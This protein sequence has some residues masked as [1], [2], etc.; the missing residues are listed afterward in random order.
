MRNLKTGRV[1]GLGLALAALVCVFAGFASNA[2][3][4]VVYDQR[5]PLTLSMFVPCAN[6]GAGEVVDVTGTWHAFFTLVQQGGV[7]T[8]TGH[9][10]FEGLVGMGET[11]GVT[12]HGTWTQQGYD[13]TVV[14]GGVVTLT[15]SN[16]IVFA[17]E[18]GAGTF[19]WIQIAHVTIDPA[20]DLRVNFDNNFIGCS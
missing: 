18:G 5:F 2:R 7:F 9:G 8:T 1:T 17:G 13:E 16:E 10:T 6:G 11:T 4:A 12:Y 19:R 3:G 14:A 15:R 20:G